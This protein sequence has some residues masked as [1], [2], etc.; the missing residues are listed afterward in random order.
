MKIPVLMDSRMKSKIEDIMEWN[1]DVYSVKFK[2]LDDAF[3]F[4]SKV[5]LQEFL[6]NQAQERFYD[7]E[8]RKGYFDY[9]NDAGETLRYHIQS[10]RGTL[11]LLEEECLGVIVV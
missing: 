5:D 4:G 7:K 6:N 9:V 3:W 2:D 11:T 8:L 1:N 10:N